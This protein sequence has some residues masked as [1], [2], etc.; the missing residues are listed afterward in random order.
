MN[1]LIIT[2]IIREGS[3][4]RPFVVVKQERSRVRIEAEYTDKKIL[5]CATW[6]TEYNWTIVEWAEDWTGKLL[7]RLNSAQKKDMQTIRA[8]KL[9]KQGE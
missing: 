5:Y 2:E 1:T 7:S 9:L 6:D 4:N 8:S 3:P